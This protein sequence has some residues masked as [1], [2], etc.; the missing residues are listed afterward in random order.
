MSRLGGDF[1]WQLIISRLRKTG[2]Q[3]FK[4]R[5]YLGTKWEHF[6]PFCSQ[7]AQKAGFR[8]TN[9]TS[10]FALFGSGNLSTKASGSRMS[11]T[12]FCFHQ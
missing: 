2:L 10:S 12:P 7:N 9:N 1:S 6:A 5:H 3:L 8:Y 4:I 11:E